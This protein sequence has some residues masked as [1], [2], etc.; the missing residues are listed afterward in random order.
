MARTAKTPEKGWI[1]ETEKI[2]YKFL[3]P[4][5]PYGYAYRPGDFAELELTDVEQKLLQD[6][7]IITKV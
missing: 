7:G 4:G 3:K 5:A 6:R 2:L 1:I